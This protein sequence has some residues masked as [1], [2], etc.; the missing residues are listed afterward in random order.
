MW[1]PLDLSRPRKMNFDFNMFSVCSIAG[2]LF[3]EF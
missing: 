2:D 3:G 1:L